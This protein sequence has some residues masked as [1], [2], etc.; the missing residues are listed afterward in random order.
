MEIKSLL[1]GAMKQCRLYVGFLV[2]LVLYSG[3][4]RHPVKHI[5]VSTNGAFSAELVNDMYDSDFVHI[6]ITARTENNGV[7]ES[8][9]T[10]DRFKKSATLIFGWDENDKIW[11][12][13]AD[14]GLYYW[15]RT[16][17]WT[18]HTYTNRMKEPIPRFITSKEP[19]LEKWIKDSRSQ[20]RK[21]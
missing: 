12:Y 6:L 21:K 9:V 1:Y 14:S 16:P 17:S 5:E 10:E 4:Y 7:H 15:D 3:C 19:N 2:I 20:D 18:K 8:A 11:V 13:S